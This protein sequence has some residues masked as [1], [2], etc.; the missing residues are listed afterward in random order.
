MLMGI[1]LKKVQRIRYLKVKTLLLM[2]EEEKL[3]QITS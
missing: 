3:L 2:V 1:I